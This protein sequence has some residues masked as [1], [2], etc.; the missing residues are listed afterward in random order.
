M[1][2]VDVLGLTEES[3]Q[4][5][6]CRNKGP[7]WVGV[8]TETLHESSDVLKHIG[9]HG[10]VVDPLLNLILCWEFTIEQ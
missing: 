10:D 4:G 8:L 9:V 3:I 6:Y 5:R 1:R 2:I 7:H